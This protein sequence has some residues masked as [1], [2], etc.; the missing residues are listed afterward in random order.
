M[1]EVPRRERTV[2]G[3][4]RTRADIEREQAE[5]IEQHIG[6]RASELEAKGTSSAMARAQAEREFGDVMRARAQLARADERNYRAQRRRLWTTDLML[7][8]RYA[9]RSLRRS[10]GFALVVLLTLTLGMGATTSI[11]SVF[12]AYLLRPLPFPFAERLVLVQDAQPNYGPAPASYEEFRDWTQLEGPFEMMAALTRR[13]RNYEGGDYP[14][15]VRVAMVSER[16]FELTAPRLVAGRLFTTEEQQ[17][18]AAA[19]IVLLESFWRSRLGGDRRAIGSAIRLDG[20]PV[21]VVGVIGDVPQLWTGDPIVAF[22]SLTP[23]AP[24]RDRGTH[25]LSVWARLNENVDVDAAN[26]R[27]VVPATALQRERDTDHSLSV[28]PL[29]DLLIGETRPV[30]V[31]IMV[32]V[33]LVLIIACVNVAN[34]MLSRAARREQ[35][36]A[37]RAAL[38]AGRARMTRQLLVEGLVL[39]LTG[40]VAGLAVGALGARAL[41]AALPDTMPRPPAVTMDGRVLGLTVVTVIGATLLFG[42]T[43]LMVELRAT[44]S[45]L[46]HSHRSGDGWTTRGKLTRHGLVVLELALSMVLLAAASLMV[47]SFARLMNVDSGVQADGVLAFQVNLPS[48]RYDTEERRAQFYTQLEE[49]LQQLPQVEAVAAALNLPLGGSGM[50]GD[51]HI[52]GTPEE[53]VSLQ[54][55]A[56]KRVVTP[57]YF[58]VLG[59]RLLNGRLFTA[60]DR[61]DRPNVAVINE[62]MARAMWPNQNPIGRRIQSLSPDD[63]WEEIVGIVS[64]VRSDGLDRA[65]PLEILYPYAQHVGGSMAMVVRARG[66]A[67]TLVPQLRAAVSALDPLQPIFNIRIMEDVIAQT[68]AGKRL[69]LL[70]S[71]TLGLLAL[72]LAAVGTAGVIAYGVA[73]RK[74]EIGVRVALGARP[75]EV[76]T[77]IITEAMTLA[78]IGVLLGMVGGVFMGDVLRSQLFEVSSTDGVAHLAAVVT[79]L[80][81]AAAAAYIPARRVLQVDP[82]SAMRAE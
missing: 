62:S 36:F 25:Y 47:R 11:F 69:L 68:I 7:D 24:W 72:L 48:A 51:F 77:L 54:P 28:V 49:R 61:A 44:L 17:E 80:G 3:M 53:S 15:R 64:D 43:P 65:P 50:N 75:R 10:P 19:T 76:L 81:A 71:T 39:S 57:D 21:T 58:A 5:E 60:E 8:V 1:K 52:E 4:P 32:T 18:G 46:L 45:S 67:V 55:A 29:R 20:Q 82:L 79:L 73:R 2:A 74:R 59:I 37:L 26:Q 16:F 13:S 30:F 63:E 9:V 56:E 70:L 42:V 33:V 35:E 66:D 6:Q 78:V 23:N 38:G 22:Q 34:L 27:L 41:L 14:E 40:A 12:N 31:A